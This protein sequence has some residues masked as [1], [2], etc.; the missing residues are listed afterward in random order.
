MRWSDTR[1]PRP[2]WPTR[3]DRVTALLTAAGGEPRGEGPGQ[4]WRTGRYRGPYLRDPLLDAGVLV[5]TLETVTF[6]SNLDN[7]KAAVTT[8][9][10][11]ALAGQG[12]QALVMC[13]ISHVYY[14]G[15]SLY[16]TV[17][18][19]QGED[20]ITQWHAAK[21]AANAA[22]RG[23][24]AAITHHHGV[25]TDHRETFAEEIG[26]LAVEVLRAAKHV[27]DPLGIVN[28]GVLIGAGT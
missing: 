26:P 21:V 27:L 5:E 18:A 7:L 16:F 17:V 10:T 19:A 20:P 1:G 3:R 13:H 8:A 28:P 6:W 23:T 15:A 24:G 25:G 12:T 14:S 4:A 22:I 9:L 2:T 11:E